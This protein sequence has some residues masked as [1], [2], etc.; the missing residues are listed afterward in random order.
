MPFGAFAPL[1]ASTSATVTAS[2]TAI[3]VKTAIASCSVN[4]AVNL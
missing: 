3:H 4:V 1:M 2:M